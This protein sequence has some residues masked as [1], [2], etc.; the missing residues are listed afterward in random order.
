[1]RSLS[2]LERKIITIVADRQPITVKGIA[3]R[4][5]VSE[6]TTSSILSQ[7]RKASLVSSEKGGDRRESYYSLI[8]TPLAEMLRLRHRVGAQKVQLMEQERHEPSQAVGESSEVVIYDDL[9]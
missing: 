2:R 9:W 4:G 5:F 8:D 1:M 7:L 3:K 6:Q